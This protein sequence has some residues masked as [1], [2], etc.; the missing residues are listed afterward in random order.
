MKEKNKQIN[1]EA[2]LTL[3][4]YGFYFLWWYFFAYG[5]GNDPSKYKFILGMPEWFFYSCILGLLVTNVLVF[6]TVKFFFKNI[7]LEDQNR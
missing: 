3:A 7:D 1:K 4:L 2:L 5:Y 6:I